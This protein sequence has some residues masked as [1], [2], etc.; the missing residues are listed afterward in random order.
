MKFECLH[1]MLTKVEEAGL[2]NVMMLQQNWNEAMV[3]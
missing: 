3:R 1:V 2:K